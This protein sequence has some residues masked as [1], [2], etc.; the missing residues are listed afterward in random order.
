[1]KEYGGSEQWKVVCSG[2]RTG[3]GYQSPLE[4]CEESGEGSLR[5]AKTWEVWVWQEL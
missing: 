4:V 3:S 5:T 1:M 2:M